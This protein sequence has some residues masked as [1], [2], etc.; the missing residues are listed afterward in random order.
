MCHWGQICVTLVTWTI[1]TILSMSRIGRELWSQR[2]LAVFTQ[3]FTLTS[4]SNGNANKRNQC[5][6]QTNSTIRELGTRCNNGTSPVATTLSP[7]VASW[8]KRSSKLGQ[9]LCIWRLVPLVRF[10]QLLRACSRTSRQFL[11]RILRTR[12][13]N[14]CRD[15]IRFTEIAVS[16]SITRRINSSLLASHSLR[17]SSRRKRTPEPIWPQLIKLLRKVPINQD[18]Y[19]QQFRRHMR[20]HQTSRRFTSGTRGLHSSE[21]NTRAKS[22]AFLKSAS[23]STTICISGITQKCPQQKS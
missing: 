3:P 10:W 1:S 13:V 21:A 6:G 7:R 15:P 22:R 16:N 20:I 23:I 2:Y 8:R 12:R 4:L 17:S 11:P 5:P 9:T 19:L 18:S 14:H